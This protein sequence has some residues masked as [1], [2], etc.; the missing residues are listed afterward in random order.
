V[1]PRAHAGWLA[2]P[3]VDVQHARARLQPP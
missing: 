2:F 3:R 1:T